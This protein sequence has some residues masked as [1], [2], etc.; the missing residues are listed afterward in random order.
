MGVGHEEGG[1]YGRCLGGKSFSSILLGAVVG[2][3]QINLTGAML[4][5]GEMDLIIAMCGILESGAYLLA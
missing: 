4:A 5:R 2:G 1:F 3:L